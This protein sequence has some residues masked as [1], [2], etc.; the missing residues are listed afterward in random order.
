MRNR[1]ARAE[2]NIVMIK[3][4]IL[5]VSN[6]TLDSSSAIYNRNNIQILQSKIKNQ[7]IINDRTIQYIKKQ[8]TMK[9]LFYD[10]KE[11]KES[12]KKIKNK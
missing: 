4:S 1:I 11:T 7:I 5:N 3:S 9:D 8:K 12:K 10:I 6:L 2:A